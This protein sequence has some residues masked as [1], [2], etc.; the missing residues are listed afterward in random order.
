MFDLENHTARQVNEFT[1]E[2]WMIDRPGQFRKGLFESGDGREA[3]IEPQGKLAYGKDSAYFGKCEVLPSDLR[4][5]KVRIAGVKFADE[6]HWG[7]YHTYATGKPIRRG[8]EIYSDGKPPVISAETE[9]IVRESATGQF[10][11]TDEALI[12]LAN[13]T[14]RP[15][16]VSSERPPF[17]E[18]A[19]AAGIGGLL[20]L[21]AVMSAD[22]TVRGIRVVRGLSHG[23]TEQAVEV[24]RH[25]KFKPA[26]KDGQP[27]S[28]RLPLEYRFGG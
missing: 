12:E 3:K 19:A 28:V 23:L 2:Q 24:T 16:I 13:V 5:M 8:L 14:T 11:E 10:S 1:Y 27:V 26:T 18:E 17:L 21:S 6:P 20:I 4:Q 9:R 25:I 22:G 15:E 7:S